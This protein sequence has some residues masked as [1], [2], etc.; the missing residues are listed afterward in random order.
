MSTWDDL[1]PSE[2]KYLK[3]DDC[4]EEGRN[5]TIKRFSRETV[6]QGQDADERAVVHW[7]EDMKPMVLNKTNASRLKVILKASGPEDAVGK[8][9]NVYNDPLIEFGGKIVGGLR[10]RQAQG[11]TQPPAQ[12]EPFNDSIPF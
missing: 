3:K 6:G 8:K 12:E 11:G 10:I 4:G 1:V 9:V 7:E 5:L 2:S